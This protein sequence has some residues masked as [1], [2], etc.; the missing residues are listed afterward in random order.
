MPRARAIDRWLTR[1][2]IEALGREAAMIRAGDASMPR[3]EA[4]PGLF[5]DRE[6]R[7]FEDRLR[8][9]SDHH[10]E[11]A[12]RIAALERTAA[13]ADVRVTLAIAFVASR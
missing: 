7:A 11:A 4:Q 1:R 5:D 12:G 9:R 10:A 2:R 6:R 8:A 13:P 3:A